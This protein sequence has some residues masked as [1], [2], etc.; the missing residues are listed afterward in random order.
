VKCFDKCFSVIK[1]W[2]AVPLHFVGFQDFFNVLAVSKDD[3][4]PGI[5]VGIRMLSVFPQVKN[6]AGVFLH[7]VDF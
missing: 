3:P 5:K 1:K 6:R 4:D 2:A 7:F